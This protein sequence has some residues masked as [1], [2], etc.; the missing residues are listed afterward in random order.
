[1][2]LSDVATFDRQGFAMLPRLIA[3]ETCDALID[4]VGDAADTKAGTR[5]LLDLACVAD[6]AEQLRQHPAVAALLPPQSKVMQ[7]NLFAKHAATNWAVTP[8]QDLSIPVAQP[9]GL[10]GW[11]GWSRK[12]GCWFAQPPVA[13]LQQ[14]VAVRLQLDDG[15]P[16]AG[17][18]EVVP[19]SHA[20][21]RL[22][23]AALSRQAALTRFSCVVSR[24]GAL[25]MR[26][27][28]VH[29]S[30]KSKVNTPRRVLH[31]VYGPSRLLDA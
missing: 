26:P 25:L 22:S 1:M 20:L 21:G 31:F 14:L 2:V 17:P 6:T 19:G 29:A 7:C 12:E 28:I 18:L 5:R 24:G 30:G 8:H 10:P 3:D 9:H 13:I 11:S 27:L 16:A 4:A 23:A 15:D